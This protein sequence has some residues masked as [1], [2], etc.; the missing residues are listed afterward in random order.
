MGAGE[1]YDESV[2]WCWDGEGMGR[3]GG[4]KERMAKI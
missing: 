1:M 3:G 2:S 4:V